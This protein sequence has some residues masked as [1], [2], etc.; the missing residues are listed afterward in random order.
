MRQEF[1]QWIESFGAREPRLLFLTGDL[2]FGAFENIVSALGSRFVNVGVCEQNMISLAAGL[3]QQGLLPLCYSIAPFAVFR[4]FEQIRLDVALHRLNVK[5]VGNG[6]GYFYGLAGAS[7]HALE[8]IA[9][10]STL[11]DFGCFIPLCNSDVDAVCEALFRYQGPSYLR[12]DTGVWPAALGILPRFKPCRRLKTSATPKVTVAGM[13]PIL[14]ETLEWIENA[15]V[16]AIAQLPL[17]ELS[18]EF[19]E[20]V[21]ATGVLWVIEEHVERGG[22]GEHLAFRLAQNGVC[23]KLHHSCALG[24]PSERYGSQAYHRRCSGLDAT[25][26]KNY[27][28]ER[29]V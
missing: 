12:L 18:E 5:I 25:S 26:L 11:Q 16:F 4:P 19:V 8:D 6:G 3:A 13:G 10:L 15:T 23:F 29:I 7:H 17:R 14:L 1:S 9:V 28:C 20:S 27:F 22:L 2:G 24:Y 21:R